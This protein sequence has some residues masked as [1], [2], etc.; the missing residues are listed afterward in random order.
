MTKRIKLVKS[1]ILFLVSIWET[2]HTSLNDDLSEAML[3]EKYI[4]LL[5]KLN[6]K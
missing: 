3:I 2:L 5:L 1:F 4:K 6:P